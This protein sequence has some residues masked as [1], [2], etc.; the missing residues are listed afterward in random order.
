MFSRVLLSA[1]VILGMTGPLVSAAATPNRVYDLM[2]RT[3]VP[4]SVNPEC[5]TLVVG[6]KPTDGL[7]CL[8]VSGGNLIVTYS[9]ATDVSY[10]EVHVWIGTGVPPTTAPGQFPYTT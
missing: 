3:D 8:T 1:A 5:K 10:K 4:T 7:V 2:R 6:Q 9:P